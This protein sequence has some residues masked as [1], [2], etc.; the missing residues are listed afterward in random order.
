MTR[1]LLVDDEAFFAASFQS[2][3]DWAALGCR[4]VGVAADGIQALEA[5]EAFAPDLIF[6]DIMMPRMD[7][8]E[9]LQHL[10]EAGNPAQVVML[11]GFNQ[12]D[13]A[14]RAMRLGAD[15]YVYKA[16]M[17]PDTLAE[18]V[19]RLQ[20]KMQASRAPAPPE[21][22]ARPPA[23]AELL[24]R[25]INSQEDGGGQG[26]PALQIQPVNLYIITLT[27][28]D[29]HQ[30][31]R[32]YGDKRHLL[33]DG[34]GSLLQEL[35]RTRTELETLFYDK[36]T[37]C[38]VKS[39]SRGSS[40]HAMHQELDYLAGKC[41]AEM[42]RFYNLQLF[43]GISGGHNGLDQLSR[44][45]DEAFSAG[46]L[47]YSLEQNR[48]HHYGDMQQLKVLEYLPVE[49]C[50]AALKQA[51]ADK[52]EAACFKALEEGFLLADRSAAVTSMAA[53]MAAHNIL[54]ALEPDTAQQRRFE[55]EIERAA[56]RSALVETLR[57]WLR[58]LLQLG[59]AGAGSGIVPSALQLVHRQYADPALSL[60]TVAKQV[61]ANPSYLSRVFK[62]ETGMNLTDH[63]NRVRVHAAEQRLQTTGDMIYQI[64]EAV[65]YR[66][67]EYFNRSF[68]KYTRKSPGDYRR[69]RQG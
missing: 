10:K 3:I 53:R 63:I 54:H 43:C 6:L 4:V 51:L 25:L 23:A 52:D 39:F 32:R 8:L 13:Y 50:T 7:G 18:M 69:G 44:A 62:R 36:Q 17:G 31:A 64:A 20:Q 35:T 38:I 11:T 55:E 58:G 16:D 45:F 9:T 68:K 56:M 40:K 19:R 41:L 48:G 21:A 37:F 24:R 12:F 28:A 49:A 26:A 46:M 61:G 1:V 14:I 65:G 47:E 5:V 33:Y 30:V 59:G 66:S 34:I 60:E 15:D 42:R 2:Y 67:V 27:L 22:T 57:E 29:F